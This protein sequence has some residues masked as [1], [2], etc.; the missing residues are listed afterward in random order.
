MDDDIVITPAIAPGPLKLGMARG[1][2]EIS[3]FFP[4]LLLPFSGDLT[5]VRKQHPE[6]EK[7]N[8]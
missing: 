2:N 7:T 6:S 8:D 5:L 4:R 1:L 3:G